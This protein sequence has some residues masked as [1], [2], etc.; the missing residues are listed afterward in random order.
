MCGTDTLSS[1]YII[2]LVRPKRDLNLITSFH[3]FPELWLDW[4][5]DEEPL[6]VIP[7]QKEYIT[8]LYDKAVKDYTSEFFL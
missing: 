1:V 7:Q 3:F 2:R 4:I 8:S 5:K 6:V